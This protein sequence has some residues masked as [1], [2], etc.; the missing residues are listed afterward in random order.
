MVAHENLI[1]IKSIERI[2]NAFLVS[3]AK[4]LRV[5]KMTNSSVCLFGL[6]V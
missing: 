2:Q 6:P 4:S 1:E 3:I 5:L